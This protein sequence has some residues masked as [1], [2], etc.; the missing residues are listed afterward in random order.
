MF[1]RAV[2][3]SKQLLGAFLDIPEVK[4]N[5]FTSRYFKVEVVLNNILFIK[6]TEMHQFTI[7]FVSGSDSKLTS[8]IS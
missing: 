5:T 3:L 4:T 6:S 2:R 1:Y 7:L 8:V